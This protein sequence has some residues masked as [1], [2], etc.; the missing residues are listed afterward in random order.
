M[1]FIF[2]L[3][4]SIVMPNN[5]VIV[6]PAYNPALLNLR[7][8]DIITPCK[9]SYLKRPRL[10]LAKQ[11]EEMKQAAKELILLLRKEYQLNE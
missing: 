6:R 5:N 7:S 3:F 4:D 11:E 2:I 10:A 8:H 1:F 9:V